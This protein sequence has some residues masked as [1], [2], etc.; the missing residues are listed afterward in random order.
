MRDSIFSYKTFFGR[1]ELYKEAWSLSI[2]EWFYLITPILFLSL[3]HLQKERQKIVLF[4][5]IAIIAGETIFRNYKIFAHN[6]KDYRQWG[7]YA[8]GVVTTRLDSIM[9]GVL[10]A[11]LAYNNHRIWQY[12]NL[13]FNC[14][15]GMFVFIVVEFHKLE[16]TSLFV[17]WQLTLESIASLLVIPK[18]S[19]LKDGKGALFR[20]FTF[21]SLIS[22]SMYLLNFTPFYLLTNDLPIDKHVLF[23]MNLAWDF[24]ASYLLYRLIEKPFMQLRERIPVF[25]TGRKKHPKKRYNRATIMKTQGCKLQTINIFI[26]GFTAE[27]CDPDRSSRG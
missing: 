26:M 25:G 8:A 13:M 10:G 24:G 15:C 23:W 4:W 19:S 7:L 27:A 12:K 11:W 22:Y 18:L 20:F 3:S 14:G 6:Y 16:F 21:T 9:Y 17:Y 1:R 5:I 2:E